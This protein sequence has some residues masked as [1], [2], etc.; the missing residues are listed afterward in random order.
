MAHIL[1]P[2]YWQ[3][4]GSLTLSCLCTASL[5]MNQLPFVLNQATLQQS[6]ILTE[7]TVFV[8]YHSNSLSVRTLLQRNQKQRRTRVFYAACLCP[9]THKFYRGNVSFLKLESGTSG[10]SNSPQ[11]PCQIQTAGASPRLDPQSQFG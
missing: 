6:E 1:S 7:P 4:D 9:R 3:M 5:F 11:V 10:V 8:T 2:K